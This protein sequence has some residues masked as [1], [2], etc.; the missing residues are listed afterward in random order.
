MTAT[1]MPFGL[2]PAQHPSG[3]DRTVRGQI[4]SGYAANIYFNDPVKLASTGY[5]QIAG[6]TGALIGTFMGCE[7]RDTL[8]KPVFSNF[9]ATGTTTF[10]SADVTAW[11][12][13]DP[14][15]IYEI[16]A[17]GSL[18]MSASGSQ[19]H[20]TAIGTTVGIAGFSQATLDTA[21]LTN[22]GQAQLR[23][24]DIGYYV[25]NAWG[26]AFTLVRVQISLHQDVAAI[27]AY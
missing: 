4:V 2:R 15:C 1:N 24:L 6:S 16:Q 17:N 14:A 10:G 25:D 13:R 18:A 20:M 5:L 9:W 22:S 12:T 7:Y 26:D 19:A 8:N 3:L 27:N 23:I 11:H 21:T